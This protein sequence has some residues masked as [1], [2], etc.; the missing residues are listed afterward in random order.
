LI[1]LIERTALMPA[2]GMPIPR[3]IGREDLSS[4]GSEQVDFIAMHAENK[5]DVLA[6]VEEQRLLSWAQLVALRNRVANALSRLGVSVGDNVVNWSANCTE[7]VATLAAC[8]HIGAV[9]TPMNHRLK[10]EEAAYILDNSRAQVV[11]VDQRFLAVAAECQAM[12]SDVA[13]WVVVGADS[14]DWAVSLD[15]L[16][17]TSSD[18]APPQVEDEGG[19]MIYTSGTTGRPKGALRRVDASLSAGVFFVTEL[20]LGIEGVHLVAG[21]LY[22]SAP[23]A[24]FALSLGLGNTVV[25]MRHFEPEHAIELIEQYGVTST[26][27]AP[28]L[29]KRVVTLPQQT[30]RSHDVS[31][32]RS[33]VVAGA[34]C[35]QSTKEAAV[36]I[37][38]PVVYE[39]Y[40]STE[41]G[42][43]TL[44]KPEDIRRKPGSCGKPFG[45]TE[46]RLYDEAGHVVSEPGVPGELCVRTGPGVFDGYFENPEASRKMVHDDEWL[47]VGDIAYVDDEGFYFICDRKADMIISGGVNIYPAEIEEV[48]HRHPEVADVGVFGIPD[49]EWGERVH[50]AVQALPDSRLTE[51]DIMAFVSDHLADYKRPRS[52]SFHEELPR[53]SAGK[54]LKRVLRE[55]Y[56]EGRTTRV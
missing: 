46:L 24:F 26:F 41:L 35:P 12:G 13:H 10:A 51:A 32:M 54:L 1:E 4:L 11:V 43:N 44:L 28:T 52:V 8:S 33:L 16:V 22:H 23:L 19:T 9:V 39:F 30:T 21:P 27:M 55:P 50:A 49:E 42:I 47:S 29:L 3:E 7:G 56:W 36:D 14:P 15:A 34:P 40:G 37:F 18:D 31:S 20:G 38:G 53:D 45:R 6:L 17:S 25:L 5:P 48:L 2:G